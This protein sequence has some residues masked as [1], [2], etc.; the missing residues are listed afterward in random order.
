MAMMVNSDINSLALHVFVKVRLR[1][2]FEIFGLNGSICG[3]HKM[4][5]DIAAIPDV[6]AG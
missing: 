4:V 5:V 6:M 3:P 2:I 1:M